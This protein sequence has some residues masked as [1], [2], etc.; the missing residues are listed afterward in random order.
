MRRFLRSSPQ[1]AQT[2]RT[3]TTAHTGTGRNSIAPYT[4]PSEG[5]L[6]CK[7]RLCTASLQLRAGILSSAPRAPAYPLCAC[8]TILC[9]RQTIVEVIH[10][11]PRTRAGSP[12]RLSRLNPGA[13]VWRSFSNTLKSSQS[14]T[15]SAGLPPAGRP[16]QTRAP[17]RQDLPP[18]RPPHHRDRPQDRRARRA[19]LLPL[20]AQRH[21]SKGPTRRPRDTI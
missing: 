2:N 7:P 15:V 1:T 19:V 5:A 13:A 14:S 10:H 9:A 4:H 21:S 20:P 11:R 16:T 17:G 6:N 3:C 8:Q 18:V 12:G